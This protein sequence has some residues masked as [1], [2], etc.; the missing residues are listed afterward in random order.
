M[1]FVIWLLKRL[2]KH[3]IGTEWAWV[4]DYRRAI[5]NEP[6]MAIL[7]TVLCGFIWWI[8]LAGLAIY[9]LPAEYIS[10][11]LALIFFSVPAFYVYHWLVALYG[12]YDRER[13]KMWET[14]KDEH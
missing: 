5:L 7:A 3:T 4:R 2:K 6:W 12:V 10:L 11:A 13:M 1:N 14:L 8:L 9:F